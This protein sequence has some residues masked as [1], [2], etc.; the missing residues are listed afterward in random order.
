MSDAYVVSIQD[1]R[2]TVE[3]IETQSIEITHLNNY[4]TSQDKI[5]NTL[6]KD[7]TDLQSSVS[8]ERKAWES[9]IAKLQKSLKKYKNPW[10]LGIFTGYDAID[11][12][13]CIGVGLTYSFWKF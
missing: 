12:N 2:D 7:V 5:I 4:I 13:L 11:S 10:S 8:V 1:G 9:N 3:L 6:S